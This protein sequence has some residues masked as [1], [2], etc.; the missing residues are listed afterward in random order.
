MKTEADLRKEFVLDFVAGT[1]HQA[2]AAV[3]L[4]EI[5]TLTS[6]RFIWRQGKDVMIRHPESSETTAMRKSGLVLELKAA[7]HELP[8]Y[9]LIDD[10]YT[11]LD[12]RLQDIGYAEVG[13]DTERACLGIH[14]RD[15]YQPI[16]LHSTKSQGALLFASEDNLPFLVELL[17]QV[18]WEFPNGSLEEFSSH[19]IGA[20]LIRLGNGITQT[21]IP[22]WANP[23]WI[24]EHQIPLSSLFTRRAPE[25]AREFG[26]FVTLKQALKYVRDQGYI[27]KILP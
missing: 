15:G 9:L 1:A 7:E 20:M 19:I 26:P 13:P 4:Q 21:E 23:K 8:Y 16:V 12:N 24:K 22:E 11:I 25:L 5:S 18:V 27:A 17:M 3:L 14:L 2:K 6:Y 10:H